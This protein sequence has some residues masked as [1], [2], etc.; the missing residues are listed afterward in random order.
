VSING[1]DTFGEEPFLGSEGRPERCTPRAKGVLPKNP[2][3]KT[4]EIKL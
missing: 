4:G 2:D 3:S 1:A